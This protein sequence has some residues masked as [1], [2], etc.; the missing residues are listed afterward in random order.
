M[1]WL[2]KSWPALIRPS[3]RYS[4]GAILIVGAVL[5][6]LLWGGF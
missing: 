6:I 4:L 3:S 1:G 2:R 5:G